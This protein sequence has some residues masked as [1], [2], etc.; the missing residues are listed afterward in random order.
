M[1]SEARLEI[2]FKKIKNKDTKIYYFALKFHMW[3]SK[4]YNLGL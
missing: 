1:P 2:F 3:S 4:L